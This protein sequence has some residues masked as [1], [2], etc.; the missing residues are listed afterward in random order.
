MSVQKLIGQAEKLLDR[1]KLDEGIEKLREALKQDPKN[2]NAANRLARAYIDNE[3]P[4]EAVAI[5]C[6]MAKYAGDAGRSNKAIALYRQAL[7]LDPNNIQIKE[8][9]SGELQDQGQDAEAIRLC[10]EVVSFYF[11]RKKFNQALS[12]VSR[13]INLDPKDQ[14]ALTQWFELLKYN[15][16]DEQLDLLISTLIGAPGIKSKET[17]NAKPPDIRN[18]DEN[19]FRLMLDLSRW[20]PEDP[21]LL[22][23]LAW[24]RMEQGR[25]EEAYPLIKEAFRRR[26]LF[27]L[28]GL[29]YARM[30]LVDNKLQP[31]FF[32]Y[33]FIRSRIS[34]DKTVDITV[35]KAEL[36]KLEKDFGWLV[37]AED[38]GEDVL[39]ASEFIQCFQESSDSGSDDK[40]APVPFEN[41]DAESK[42]G[43]TSKITAQAEVSLSDSAE[44]EPST[45]IEFTGGGSRTI[46]LGNFAETAGEEPPA[47]AAPTVPPKSLAVP[48]APPA[49]PAPQIEVPSP[50][51]EGAAEQAVALPVVSAAEDDESANTGVQATSDDGEM[52]IQFSAPVDEEDEEE[53]EEDDSAEETVIL[54]MPKI[55]LKDSDAD[56]GNIADN[57]AEQ[58]VEVSPASSGTGTEPEQEAAT[59]KENPEFEESQPIMVSTFKPKIVFEPQSQFRDGVPPGEESVDDRQVTHA[60]IPTQKNSDFDTASEVGDEKESP[61]AESQAPDEPAIDPLEAVKKQRA[62][63]KVNIQKSVSAISNDQMNDDQLEKTMLITA[64]PIESK[65][66][67]K[68]VADANTSVTRPKL[69]VGEKPKATADSLAEDDSVEATQIISRE[70]TEKLRNEVEFSQK[71]GEAPGVSDALELPEQQDEATV[72]VSPEQASQLFSEQGVEGLLEEEFS[73]ESEIEPTQIITGGLDLVDEATAAEDSPFRVKFEPQPD[74]T[75]Q[76][77]TAG[78]PGVEADSMEEGTEDEEEADLGLDLLEDPT[79]LLHISP[80]DGTKVIISD[81]GSSQLSA[82]SLM[83][84]AERYLIRGD[85]YLARKSFR[86]ALSLG[87]DENLVKEKLREIRKRELPESLYFS[88]SHDQPVE[89]FKIEQLRADLERDLDFDTDHQEEVISEK[90]GLSEKVSEIIHRDGPQYGLDLGVALHEMGFYEEARGVFAD[91]GQIAP[92]LHFKAMYLAAH[93][94]MTAKNYAAAV[95]I[96]Q[97]LLVSENQNDDMVSVYYMLGEVYEKLNQFNKSSV[98]YRKVAEIDSH[99]RNVQEKLGGQF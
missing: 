77:G 37:F 15:N 86:Q 73:G 93:S 92:E 84:R 31:G 38:S 81:L 30:L 80:E 9:L 52:Q 68:G 45:E 42:E 70:E 14:S 20:I 82:E 88:S 19:V 98:F 90:L 83:E 85:Y 59:S 63:F 50:P 34:E 60:Q 91:V 33:D 8:K 35:S 27:V 26:P 87:A 62:S 96:L 1:G 16:T 40:E 43:I 17:A 5:F 54:E 2:E 78:D 44:A 94:M 47:V 28:N 65:I 66:I 48:V 74:L 29:L 99:Y 64:E 4:F 51:S 76:P 3:E 49:P 79:Q 75:V 36:D 32:V 13:L 67:E 39:S 97:K 61:S 10:K 18:L 95:G 41:Q 56:D 21:K 24:A 11:P 25:R 7:N 55:S 6:Q 72:L 69:A 89:K 46:E 23:A 57:I 22:H 71:S 53:Y 12:A 58:A